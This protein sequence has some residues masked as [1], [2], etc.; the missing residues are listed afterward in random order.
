[1]SIRF[2]AAL[3]ALLFL[4]PA[5]DSTDNGSGEAL[6]VQTAE[7]IVADPV[8]SRDPATGA[9]ITSGRFTFYSLRENRVVLNYD[10]TN[11]ADS[12]ST[13]WDIA[14]RGTTILINGGTS[15]P[16][17]GGAVVV[18]DVF[19]DV[20][21]APATINVDG[22]NT[23]CTTRY[24]ICTGSGNGWYTYNPA[25]NI[26]APT[27][28][29]TLVIRNADGT[30]AKVRILSYYEGNPA[31]IDPNT[32]ADRHYTFEYIYQPDGSRSFE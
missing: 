22:A 19:E 2:F 4:L 25:T 14:F 27:P 31:T 15:G 18:E 13:K 12:A 21:E 20:L 28:G 11:R 16:G 6:D 9:T 1:M 5:C 26:V 23:A 17:Q 8:V 24:A 30:F 7:D 29:R 32:D 10:N 3:L